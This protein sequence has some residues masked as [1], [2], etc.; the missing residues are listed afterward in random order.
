MAIELLDEETQA[1]VDRIEKMLRLAANN[2]N[3]NERAAAE[4]KAHEYL[5]RFNLDMATV[6]QHGGTENGRRA[7]E[8]MKGGHYEY[9]RDLWRAVAELNFCMYWNMVARIEEKKFLPDR[10][11][12]QFRRHVVVR[13]ERQHRLVGRIHNVILTRTMCEY[14]EAAVE[15]MVAEDIKGTAEQ[16]R[17]TSANSYRRGCF[18][19]VCERIYEKRREM[20][21]EDERNARD[22]E[23]KAREAGKAGVSTGTGI[24]LRSLAQQERDANNDFILGEDGASARL[25]AEAVEQR[26]ENAR[27]AAEIEA[28]NAQ[29]AADHP[30]EAA[31]EAKAERARWRKLEA[32]RDYYWRTK[33]QYGYGRREPANDI[34]GD[35]GAYY[36]GREKGETISID[37]QTGR[38]KSAGALR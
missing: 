9:Q 28:E 19:R 33:G 12:N 37:A 14:I 35:A 26:A 30:E 11:A 3:E 25:R 24:T 6:E 18:Q 13:H 16:S 32:S 15:R 38:N 23:I 36:R 27:I 4:A 21:A 2:P 20:I 8:K 7:D 17:G 1:V 10:A 34:K 5:A 29:W 22:A 31:A